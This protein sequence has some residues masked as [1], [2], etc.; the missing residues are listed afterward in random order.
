MH[1]RVHGQGEGAG[2]QGAGVLQQFFGFGLD[3]KQALGDAEQ[4]LAQVG[5]AHG[6]F[7][8][9]KQQHAEAFFE[10][11][12]LVGNRRLRQEQAFSGLSETAV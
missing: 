3:H 4:T 9:V 5:E 7:V 11:A 12:H 1:G 6:A 10:L 2:E 8:A